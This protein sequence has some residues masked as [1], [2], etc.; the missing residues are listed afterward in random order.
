MAV[1]RTT[2]LSGGPFSV[3]HVIPRH[4]GDKTEVE[5]Q[6][7]GGISS[8]KHG[9]TL[10]TGMTI[11]AFALPGCYAAWFSSMQVNVLV[12]SLQTC[13]TLLL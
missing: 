5:L 1:V 12:P 13:C 10:H 6:N 7:L 8:V 2:R 3:V 9:F 11:E 4:L